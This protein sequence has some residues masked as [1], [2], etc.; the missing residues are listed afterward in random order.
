LLDKLGA[1]LA[2]Q[3]HEIKL[4]GRRIMQP[5]LSCWY[6]DEGVSYG[7]SGLKLEALPWHPG[8][9]NLRHRLET[10]LHQPFNSVL[11]NAYRDGNDSM[12]WHADDEPELGDAPTI[13][14][15]SLGYPRRFLVRSKRGKERRAM[16]LGN[17]SLLVMRGAAQSAYQHALPKTLK[18]A[19]YRINLTFR[20]VRNG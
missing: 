10:E 1:E 14:S 20:N 12:G 8:L 6:G 11:A 5:R 7:Y 16:M 2:W 17:G 18:T 13:A 4:F 9:Q 15:L 19:G 3:R